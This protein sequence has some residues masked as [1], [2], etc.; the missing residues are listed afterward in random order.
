VGLRQEEGADC[1]TWHPRQCA[2]RPEGSTSWCPP[3][4][5]PLKQ[6]EAGACVYE[7]GLVPR[8]LLGC[9]I[10]SHSSPGASRP[11]VDE[12]NAAQ[13]LAPTSWRLDLALCFSTAESPI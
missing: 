1:G 12:G 4:L 6:A 2:G 3:T 11:L 7:G 10:L 9:G 8:E 13:W 5:P